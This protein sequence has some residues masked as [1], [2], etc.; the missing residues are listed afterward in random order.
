MTH[1]PANLMRALRLFAK[2][3]T[4][5]G[6]TE[7]PDQLH[8]SISLHMCFGF[9]SDDPESDRKIQMVKKL[10]HDAKGRLKRISA[11]GAPHRDLDWQS[12]GLS[13]QVLPAYWDHQDCFYWAVE[14]DDLVSGQA[15]SHSQAYHDQLR[16]VESNWIA[17]VNSGVYDL[18]AKINHEI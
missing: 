12:L 9:E 4:P 8:W 16:W 2:D 6:N 7:I 5:S 17:V 3:D 10:W 18:T 1:D 15:E 11:D 13:S 14:I